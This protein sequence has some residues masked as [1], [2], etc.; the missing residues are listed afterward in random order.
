VK[1]T[2]VKV[3]QKLSYLIKFIHPSICYALF[4]ELSIIAV[5]KVEFKGPEQCGKWIHHGEL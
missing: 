4:E 1:T 3:T 5:N 2:N